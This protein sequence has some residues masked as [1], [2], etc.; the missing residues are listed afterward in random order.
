[1]AIDQSRVLL[2]FLL[3]LHEFLSHK[4]LHPGISLMGTYAKP[5]DTFHFVFYYDSDT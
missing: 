3:M 4:R 2:N 5:L 1:M